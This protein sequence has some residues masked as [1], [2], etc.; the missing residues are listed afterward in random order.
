MAVPMSYSD[1]KNE[2]DKR[3]RYAQAG[4]TYKSPEELR[5]EAAE[6]RSTAQETSFAGRTK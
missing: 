4:V 3:A 2:Q 1:W 5:D 6:M